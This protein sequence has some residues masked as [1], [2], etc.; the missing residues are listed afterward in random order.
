VGSIVLLRTGFGKYWGDQLK[1]TGT[2]NPGDLG[3]DELHFPG[4]AFGGAQWLVNERE[5][6]AVGIDT[7]SIDYGQSKDFLTHRF[8]CGN[9]ITAYENVANLEQ[10]P[11]KGAYVVAAPMKIKGGSGSPLRIIAWIPN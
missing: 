7:P 10:L 6:K 3:V 2:V 9:D 5:I 11:A 4:L 1:Y 8:L